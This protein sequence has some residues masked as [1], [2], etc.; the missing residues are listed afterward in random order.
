MSRS[1]RADGRVGRARRRA[2][3]A[4][5]ACVWAL[6]LLAGCATRPP[7]GAEPLRLSQVQSDDP[8]RRA[9]LRLCMNGLDADAQGRHAAAQGDYER[10]IQVDPNNPYAYLVLARQSVETGDGQR[11]LSYLSQAHTLL[12]SEDALTPGVEAHLFG[13]RG[14]ALNLIGRPGDEDLARAQRMSPSVWADG[15]LAPEELR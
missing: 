12:S 8:A 10:A 2:R 3:C 11:A 9:S 6:A 15:Q 5:H 1:R 13:L 7:S 4:A 14:S